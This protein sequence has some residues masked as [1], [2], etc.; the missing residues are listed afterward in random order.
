[1]V[2]TIFWMQ[3]WISLMIAVVSLIIL[4]L[5]IVF[6]ICFGSKKKDNRLYIVDEKDSTK[7]NVK[8]E[9]TTTSTYNL[10]IF[11]RLSSHTEPE[12]TFT[13]KH[14]PFYNLKDGKRNES[15]FVDSLDGSKSFDQLI[16]KFKDTD[17]SSI[18]KDEIRPCDS[19]ESLNSFY[20]AHRSTKGTS[21]ESFF[22]LISEC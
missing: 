6:C 9:I 21:R 22:S 20:S 11:R 3:S 1:M 10:N 8:K 15:D 2:V 19:S 12:N 4:I 17:V 7:N 13:S 5:F 16:L 14:L 18:P